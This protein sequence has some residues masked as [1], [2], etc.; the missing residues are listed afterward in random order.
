MPVSAQNI[1]Q[2]CALAAR[3]KI[4]QRAKE[5]ARLHLVEVLRLKEA[6][7]EAG[8]PESSAAQLT[9]RAVQRIRALAAADPVCPVCGR[10]EPVDAIS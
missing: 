4:E 5:A 6:G 8:Y 9:S 10:S 2:L 1:D 3:K 7:M